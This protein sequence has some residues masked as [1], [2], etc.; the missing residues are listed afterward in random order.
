MFI[1][2]PFAGAAVPQDERE[3]IREIKGMLDKLPLRDLGG[4]AP[5]ITEPLSILKNLGT[6]DKDKE[7]AL[8][9]IFLDS[10]PENLRHRL[11]AAIILS[12]VHSDLG[13]S[14]VKLFIEQL[15]TI[16]AATD[17]GM[18]RLDV[19]DMF[20]GEPLRRSTDGALLWWYVED[21]II[22]LQDVNLCKQW[23]CY[24]PLDDMRLEN[25]ILGRITNEFL[26]LVVDTIQGK[27]IR[28][29]SLAYWILE[30]GKT[31][32]AGQK[33]QVIDAIKLLLTSGGISEGAKREL[34]RLMNQFGDESA[35][36]SP[37]QQA[38]ASRFEDVPERVATGKGEE[39]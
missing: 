26:P 23:L 22:V 21:I 37:S 7:T 38:P 11:E 39:H 13:V 27:G 10:R 16:Q 17:L 6:I 8:I 12:A 30:K 24:S 2:L 20:L 4:D 9:G 29:L 28:R 15:F 25:A 36:V 31:L 19:L 35:T 14:L 18:G 33:S 1:A 32:S 34:Y 5:D 3:D